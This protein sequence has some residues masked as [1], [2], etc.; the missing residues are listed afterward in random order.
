MTGRTKVLAVLVTATVAATVVLPRATRASEGVP[1]AVLVSVGGPVA[2]TRTDGTT[3]KASFGMQL[4][5]GDLV[6]TGEDGK[7]EI[8]LDGGNWLQLGSNS[9]ITIMEPRRTGPASAGAPE[10]KNFEV[11]QNFIKL[12]TSEG[13]S[14][15]TGLRGKGGDNERLIALSPCQTK[16]RGT[17]PTFRWQIDDPDTELQIVVSGPSGVLWQKEVTRATELPY[18]DD[19]PAL[20]AG[21]TYSWKLESTDPLLYPPLVTKAAYFEIMSDEDVASLDVA[22]DAI[23]AQDRPGAPAYHVVRASIYFDHGLVEEAI[24]ETRTAMSLDADNPSLRAILAQLYRKSGR[25]DLALAEYEKLIG[26]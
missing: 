5:A 6:T 7:A 22:L 23:D 9:S 3:I 17:R 16:V 8:M 14:T 24:T 19:A 10:T 21:V 20:E 2:V 1:A 4:L 11:V 12:R 25:S 26:E 18:S 15:L 13:T